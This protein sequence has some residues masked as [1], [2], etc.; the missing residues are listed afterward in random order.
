MGNAPNGD[1]KTD[2]SFPQEKEDSLV[3]DFRVFSPKG[4]FSNLSTNN[5]PRC[6]YLEYI[7]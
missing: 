7:C 4:Y 2:P 5:E 3:R 6:S 1:K